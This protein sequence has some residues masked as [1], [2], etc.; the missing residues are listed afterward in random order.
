[1]KDYEIDVDWSSFEKPLTFKDKEDI[2]KDKNKLACAGQSSTVSLD[3]IAYSMK[4]YAGKYAKHL[5]NIRLYRFNIVN[6]KIPRA[7][8]TLKH[9]PLGVGTPLHPYFDQIC[10]W[11]KI[12]PIQLSPHSCNH[13]LYVVQGRE[14]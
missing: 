6:F 12:A 3:E 13:T 4:Y 8:L 2:R 5:P 1:M 9:V 11:Y 10:M 14:I 7:V